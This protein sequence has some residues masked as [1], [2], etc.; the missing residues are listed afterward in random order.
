MSWWQF[1]FW[2]LELGK[3]FYEKWEPP[4]CRWHENHSRAY[5]VWAHGSWY[6]MGEWETHPSSHSD[7]SCGR[8]VR[9]RTLE[10]QGGNSGAD[11]ISHQRREFSVV[12]EERKLQRLLWG[13]SSLFDLFTLPAVKD[14]GSC[15]CF[16]DDGIS[17]FNYI[18][19]ICWLE[20]WWRRAE[21]RTFSFFFSCWRIQPSNLRNWISNV[22]NYL[23]SSL[24]IT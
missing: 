16:L 2:N 6:D 20:S 1:Y 18:I 5:K 7:C 4:P 10:G 14:T 21:W 9:R 15:K 22:W 13:I 19:S 12:F 17:K 23:F 3:A 11:W 24:Q 8:T